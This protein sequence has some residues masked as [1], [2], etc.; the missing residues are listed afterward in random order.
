MPALGKRVPV[1]DRRAF[2]GTATETA[3][4]KRKGVVAMLEASEKRQLDELGYLVLPGFVPPPMLTELRDR[5]EALWAQEGA[6]AGSEFRHEPG[7]RRLANLVD[8]GAIF[9]ALVS[10][11]KILDCMAHVIGPQYKLSSLNARSTN[12]NH[13]D[14]IRGTTNRSSSIRRRCCDPK[15]SRRSPRCSVAC[16]RSTMSRTTGSARRRRA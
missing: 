10:M 3:A 11:P 14:S 8:K 12:P 9:A 5:V 1:R 15:R 2:G 16:S 7:A 13:G 4:A 6:E